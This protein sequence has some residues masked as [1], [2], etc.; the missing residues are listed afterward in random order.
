MKRWKIFGDDTTA[1]LD[2]GIAGWLCGKIVGCAVNDQRTANDFRHLKPIGIYDT[3]SVAFVS[4]KRR[5]ITGMFRMRQTAGVIVAPRFIK[6]KRTIP[7][8][9]DMHAIELGVGRHLLVWQTGNFRFDQYAARGDR[10]KIC[11][12]MQGRIIGI[13]GN[14]S[15][16]TWA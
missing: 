8:L 14:F 15:V 13:A 7:C 4:Q 2:T 9:V 5:Q 11:D 12:S 16:G 1:D 3:V 6:R 10:I